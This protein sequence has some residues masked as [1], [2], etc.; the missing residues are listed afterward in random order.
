MW[1]STTRYLLIGGA[2]LATTACATGEEWTTWKTHPTHF[3]SGEH[4]SF[5]VSNK[6]GAPAKVTRNE[7]AMAR[8]EGWWGKPI[9]V[10][11]EQILER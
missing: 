6:E 2:L 1:R 5:S 3:A 7:I 4:M 11:Q 9:T 8:E 10:G